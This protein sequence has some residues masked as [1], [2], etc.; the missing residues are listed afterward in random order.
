[1][2]A[3]TAILTAINRNDIKYVIADSAF[4]NVK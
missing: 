3:V 4:S 2:G 1:M